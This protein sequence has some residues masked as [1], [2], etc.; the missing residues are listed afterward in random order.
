MEQKGGCMEIRSELIAS[1]MARLTPYRVRLFALAAA[2]RLENLEPQRDAGHHVEMRPGEFVTPLD[3]LAY[4]WR[5]LAGSAR[6]GRHAMRII[7]AF[8]RACG[9]LAVPCV[10]TADDQEFHN[11]DDAADLA[12]IYASAPLPGLAP[13]AWK[14]VV[15]YA[16]LAEHIP[17][18]EDGY[19][20]LCAQEALMEEIG[21]PAVLQDPPVLFPAHVVSIAATIRQ[22]R[23]YENTH[24]EYLVL[25]DALDE[26]GESAAAHH[27]RVTE[28]S[29]HSSCWVI[30]RILGEKRCRFK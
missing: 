16:Y 3:L 21:G 18:P 27:C 20:E 14:F 9:Y 26:I 10:Y 2:G 5:H 13:H 7:R 28:R 12:A 24:K 8:E 11:R 17:C 30:D 1:T 25:S 19:R 23:R 6:A 4:G 29:H 22:S 15:I